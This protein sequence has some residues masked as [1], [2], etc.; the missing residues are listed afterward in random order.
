MNCFKASAVLNESLSRTGTPAT[1]NGERCSSVGLA[2]LQDVAVHCKA[3]AAATHTLPLHI[4]VAALGPY[5]LG[6]GKPD[7]RD[8]QHAT[9]APSVA[10]A[11]LT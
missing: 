3:R 5:P 11:T 10:L 1:R 7:L 8:L 4:A 9:A 2:C 6:Q